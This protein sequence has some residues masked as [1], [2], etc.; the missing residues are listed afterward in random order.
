MLGWALAV[1]P[2]YSHKWLVGDSIIRVSGATVR[3][4]FFG[5]KS[6]LRKEQRYVANHW[7]TCR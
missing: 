2:S 4:G 6:I 7:Y 3:I 5:N 1:E